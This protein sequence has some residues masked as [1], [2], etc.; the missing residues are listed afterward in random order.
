MA[1]ETKDHKSMLDKLFAEVEQDR[2]RLKL[3]AHLFK[4]DAKDEWDK[5]E[6]KWHQFKGNTQHVGHEAKEASKGLLA[7]TQLLGEG[8][9]AGYKR[10]IGSL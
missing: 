3:Q 4:A 2:D 9:K 7:A 5:I 8:I 6:K 10:I 1:D